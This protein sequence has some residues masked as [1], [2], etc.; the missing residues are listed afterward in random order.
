[1]NNDLVYTLDPY[2]ISILFQTK[3][4]NKVL[5]IYADLL[6]DLKGVYEETVKEYMLQNDFT[7]D[8]VKKVLETEN[9]DDIDLKYQ[10]YM[11]NI[12]LLKRIEDNSKELLKAFYDQLLLKL[13]PEQ[14][15]ELDDYLQESADLIQAKKDT[16]KQ[17]L[18]VMKNI[19]DQYGVKNYDEL[20]EKVNAEKE[21]NAEAPNL[22]EVIKPVGGLYQKPANTAINLGK[23]IPVPVEKPETPVVPTESAAES[24]AAAA[25]AP[26][27]ESP[28][29]KTEP[30][31]WLNDLKVIPD[32]KLTEQP[33]ALV[34]EEEQEATPETGMPKLAEDLSAPAAEEKPLEE[35]PVMKVAAMPEPPKSADIP[36]GQ[37][38][39]GQP[40]A[41]PVSPAPV[42]PDVPATQ[43][44]V[45]S[46][47]PVETTTPIIDT[48]NSD[49]VAVHQPGV[50]VD[51][52]PPPPSNDPSKP[53]LP[54]GAKPIE[55]NKDDVMM[56]L[57]QDH[58]AVNNK[59]INAI[60]DTSDQPVGIPTMTS[61]GTVTNMPV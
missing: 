34:V 49:P 58:P 8:D 9:Y 46:V 40:A 7:E 24:P 53:V 36:A 50:V 41:V 13:S 25:P 20:V 51:M 2:I 43:A 22:D 10:P 4:D 56:P 21:K 55:D 33:N 39:A 45:L 6:Q 61:A 28:E 54:P 19:L 29:K 5:E 16:I 23:D 26:A 18:Q 3:D 30:P 17:G 27:V 52:I 44:P 37:P 32:Q 1:M 12:I 59:L 42:T 15:K 38:A 35:N 47:M 48:K 11:Q 57:A 31:S 60:L 14:K